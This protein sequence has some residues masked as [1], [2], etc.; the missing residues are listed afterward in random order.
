MTTQNF[1]VNQGL[2]A[3]SI[4]VNATNNQITGLATSGFPTNAGDAA[5]KSYVDGLTYL[6]S[7]SSGTITIGG[8][9]ATGALYFGSST[10]SQSTYLAGG[11]TGSGN[12]ATIGIGTN[13]AS[14]STTAITLGSTSGTS[15]NTL[16]GALTVT[17]ATAQTI[18]IGAS[19]GTGTITLGSSTASQTVSIANGATLATNANTINIGAGTPGSTTTNTI[20]ATASGGN[21]TLGT[22]ASYQVGT[23]ITTGPSISTAGGLAVSTT[24]YVAATTSNS[25][26]V[27]LSLTPGGPGISSFTT[28]TYSVNNTVTVGASALINIGNNVTNNIASTT[29]LGNLTVTPQ[30]GTSGVITLGA[31][32]G[33]GTI[34]VGSSTAS[35]T[36]N[37]A[38]GVTA[39]SNTNTVNIGTAGASG[40]TT[41]INIGG[42]S[43][44]STT[45]VLGT[46]KSTTITTGGSG[47]AGS[48][49]GAWT[50]T[51]TWQATYADLAERFAADAP[52]TPGAVVMLGGDAE[53]TETNVDLSDQVFGV[54]STKPGFTMNAG[55]GDDTTHPYVA[56]SG[57]AP[58][59]VIGTV[60]KGDRLVTSS[61]KGTA[62]AAKNNE[63]INP[64]HVI[65]RALESKIDA[66][67]GM[68]NCAVRTNN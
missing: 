11:T 21:V 9:S 37:L 42:S 29:I 41:N 31:A 53:I 51:G 61:I 38:N 50:L 7:Q 60:N 68:V 32:A 14:G 34:T 15:S 52:M 67:I 48:I 26:T 35:Q 59:R 64:F 6:A 46:L 66:G 47:T 2:Q 1:R 13:G 24:Y 56:M 43:G 27:T 3:G 55:S 44:T 30:T 22:S 10:G 33:T 49:T 20:T 57:R 40:S 8:A 4:V 65:G 23:P 39:I 12:T 17:P 25:T 62:R 16:V 54:I 28:T 18:I 45:T 5:T 58:V 63:S 36:T 19:A